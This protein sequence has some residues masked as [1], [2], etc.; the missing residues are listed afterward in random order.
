MANTST[1]HK[2]WTIASTMD[3]NN[4]PVDYAGMV[5]TS[6]DDII[7]VGNGDKNCWTYL[8]QG[9]LWNKNPACGWVTV[10]TGA[11]NDRL[12]LGVGGGAGS[13]HAYT[14]VNMGSGH[15]TFHVKGNIYGKTKVDMG[16][17]RDTIIVEGCIMGDADIRTGSGDDEVLVHGNILN[18]VTVN[19]EQGNNHIHVQGDVLNHATI[20]SGGRPSEGPKDFDNVVIDGTLGH[21]AKVIMGSFNDSA[22]IHKMDNFAHVDMGAGKDKLTVDSFGCWNYATVEMGSGDDEFH[23]NGKT[24]SEAKINGGSGHDTLYLHYNLDDSLVSGFSAWKPTTNLSSSNFKGFEKIVMT[25]MNV[26]DI[27]YKDLLSDDVKDGPLFI[28][29]NSDC[30]VDL[31]GC[32]WNSDTEAQ[33]NLKDNSLN[34]WSWFDKWSNTGSKTVD[35]VTYDIYHHSAAGHD[36]SN[37]VYIQQGVMVI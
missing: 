21:C 12:E 11:G 30:K 34:W 36:T 14:A 29:G 6:G 31:G 4:A 8:A 9:N 20:I 37:D 16:T 17:G 18:C 13:M 2:L 22:F 24:L 3:E 27:K 25:G 1:H 33:Q 5:T 19:L 7:Q 32:N 26:V 35:G 10:D 23:F 15:D 28:Q